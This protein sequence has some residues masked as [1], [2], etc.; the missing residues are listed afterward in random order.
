VRCDQAGACTAL[1]SLDD[2]MIVFK[3][4][5][6][7]QITGNRPNAT[8]QGGTLSTPQLISRDCGCIDWRS[9]VRGPAG[10]YFLSATG[11]YLLDRGLNVTYVGGA[12]DRFTNGAADCQS[13]KMLRDRREIR[14]EM[15]WPG[16]QYQK[17]VYNYDQDEWTTHTN[18][19]GPGVAIYDAVV[20][21]G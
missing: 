15:L 13:A 11:I 16:A 6:I 3:A 1:A 9:V 5:Q 14:W 20:G 2:K 21:P 7:Y 8:G 4:D 17:L 12:G 10:I 19:S 18:A